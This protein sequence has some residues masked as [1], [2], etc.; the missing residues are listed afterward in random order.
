MRTSYDREKVEKPVEKEEVKD[1]YQDIVIKGKLVEAYKSIEEELSYR[2]EE[3]LRGYGDALSDSANEFES[4]ERELR[5]R[6]SEDFIEEAESQ[7]KSTSSGKKKKIIIACSVI[8]A[9]LVV[10]VG[11][12]FAYKNLSK[13]SRLESVETR[14]SKLYTSK[15]KNDIKSDVSQSDLNDYYLELIDLQKDG[16]NVD[17]IMS[18]LDSI[19]YYLEN[20]G[21]LETFNS[22]SYDLTTVG[23]SDELVSIVDNAETYSVSG[24][25]VSVNN[26]A[27]KVMEDYNSF[28]GLRQELNGISDVINFDE[29]SYKSKIDMISHVPNR[30][31]LTAVYDK[32]VV[33]KQAAEAQKKLDEAADEQA[34]AEAEQA[35]KDAQELQKKTQEE[36]EST[37]KKL[38]EE[39]KK[40]AEAL[41]ENEEI[42]KESEEKVEQENPVDGAETIT[43][44]PTEGEEPGIPLPGLEG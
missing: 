18:E 40:A 41:K 9:V 14:V 34:K 11:G 22:E 3:E 12:F 25:A 4:R 44:E 43:P 7:E 38:E 32:L 24:L 19:G 28:I 27:S 26:M 39:A 15:D 13:G 10:G 35:L 1:N 5:N 33:D 36:L 31:E 17:S 21:K 16:V 30:V 42:K 20:M 29:E 6:N 2:R 8:G 37:K 23:L